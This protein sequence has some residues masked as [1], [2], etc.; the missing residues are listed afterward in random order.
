VRGRPANIRLCLHQAFAH[1]QFV[2][3]LREQAKALGIEDRILWHPTRPG[4]ISDEELNRL[5]NACA[6][7]INTAA[8]E[9]FGLVSFEHAATAVPQIVPNQAALAELWGD[10]AMRLPVESVKA[11]F[12]PLLMCQVKPDDVASALD[13]LLADPDYYARS[14]GAAFARV[15]EAELRWGVVAV[16]IKGLLSAYWVKRDSLMI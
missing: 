2:E 11:D 8:G 13:T 7:G 12:S 16:R 9:G 15:Q 4:V 1:A 6:V 10:S 14:A 5:Y 3:P